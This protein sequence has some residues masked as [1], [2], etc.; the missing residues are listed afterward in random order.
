MTV[1]QNAEK[2][3]Y[4]KITRGLKV[5]KLLRFLRLGRFVRYLHMWEEILN[6]DYGTA[7]NIVK[8]WQRSI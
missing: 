7:E 6:M 5:L 2:L 3:K 8:G 4:M 1:V